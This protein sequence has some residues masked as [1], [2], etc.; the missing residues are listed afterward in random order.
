MTL[1]T[2]LPLGAESRTAWTGPV[3][4]SYLLQ[5][6][7]SARADIEALRAHARSLSSNPEQLRLLESL[8]SY[9][10]ALQARHLPVPPA[11]RDELQLQRCLVS[12]RTVSRSA[13][14]RRA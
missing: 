13:T 1:V 6:V 14:R 10:A 4:L 12:R 7:Q 11:I 9:V 8:E 5:R 3:E 2:A